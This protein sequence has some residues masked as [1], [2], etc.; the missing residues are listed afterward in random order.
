MRE[1]TSR[2]SLEGAERIVVTHLNHFCVRS[3]SHN[4]LLC[5]ASGVSDN[6]YRKWCVEPE[7]AQSIARDLRR[8]VSRDTPWALE[9]SMVPGPQAKVRRSIIR[10][11]SLGLA[12]VLLSAADMFG[13]WVA[14]K[15]Y[16]SR[17]LCARFLVMRTLPSWHSLLGYPL[18]D[19]HRAER[20]SQSRDYLK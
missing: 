13:F 18:R 19:T 16:A 17:L 15:Y 8:V 3:R 10:L 7:L 6:Q 4:S 12:P 5:P 14:L 9:S 20:V 1:S 2:Y 11:W